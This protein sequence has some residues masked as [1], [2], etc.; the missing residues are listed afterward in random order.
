MKIA[1]SMNSFRHGSSR[2]EPGY[3]LD[4]YGLDTETTVMSLVICP[5]HNT[6]QIYTYM[7]DKPHSEF[8]LQAMDIVASRIANDVLLHY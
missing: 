5:N 6:I 3:R 7:S 1:R 2:D 8:R 4:L